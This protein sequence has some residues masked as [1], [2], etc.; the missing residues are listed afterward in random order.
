MATYS[1]LR[2]ELEELQSLLA[3]LDQRMTD[4]T[5]Q[6]DQVNSAEVQILRS[7]S[8][9]CTERIGEIEEAMLAMD[10]DSDDSIWS[11]ITQMEESDS[12][13]E[14]VDLFECPLSP[15]E[16]DPNVSSL[17]GVS[18][19]SWTEDSVQAISVLQGHEE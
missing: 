3:T 14:D 16:A 13:A 19:S 4:A 10:S 12:D 15:I 6:G 2:Q 1:H 5:F 17:L 18:V 7:F 9:L 8:A 11:D